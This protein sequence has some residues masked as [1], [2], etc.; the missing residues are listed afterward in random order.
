MLSN[1]RKILFYTYMQIC[2]Q[3][4][5]IIVT[6]LMIDFNLNVN[7]YCH[8]KYYLLMNIITNLFMVNF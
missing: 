8:V 3:Y 5:H 6:G 4:L 7:Y 2:I 1:D